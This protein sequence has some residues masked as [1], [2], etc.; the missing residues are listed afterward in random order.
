MWWGE[1]V[2]GAQGGA[3]CMSSEPA[4]RLSRGKLEE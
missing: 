3:G 2:A 1:Y 4:G